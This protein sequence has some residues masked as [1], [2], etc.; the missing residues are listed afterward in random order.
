MCVRTFSFKPLSLYRLLLSKEETMEKKEFWE[1]NKG[2]C[3]SVSPNC[4][5]CAALPMNSTV[6][7][8]SLLLDSPGIWDYSRSSRL[9]AL[10]VSLVP[11]FSFQ[12]ASP[13][14]GTA[15]STGSQ[16]LATPL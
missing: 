1:K 10:P 7:D 14:L 11:R 12:R 13:A 5:S 4:F 2:F 16:L 6:C 8:P 15:A 3:C 9:A